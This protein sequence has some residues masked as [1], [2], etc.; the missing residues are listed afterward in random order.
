MSRVTPA[1]V[2]AI[3]ATTLDDATIQLWI[4]GSSTIVDRNAPCIGGDEA[5]LTKV[6]LYLSAHNVDLNS[7]TNKGQITKQKLDVLET[8]YAAAPVVRDSIESTRYGVMANQLAGGCLD[9]YLKDTASV[10]FF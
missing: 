2:K 8:T 5:L 10:E 7:G 6:E 3:V 4:D 9:D 1:E